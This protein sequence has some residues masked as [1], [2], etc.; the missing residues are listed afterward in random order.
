M[1]SIWAVKHNIDNKWPSSFSL[2]LKKLIIAPLQT[3]LKK[4]DSIPLCLQIKYVYIAKAVDS[5]QPL[6]ITTG[7]HFCYGWF[8]RWLFLIILLATWCEGMYKFQAAHIYHLQ[9]QQMKVAVLEKADNHVI[10][11]IQASCTSITCQGKGKE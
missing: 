6:P 7:K 10:S 5:S 3:A 2:E 9:Q 1:A 11:C 8:I 4:F